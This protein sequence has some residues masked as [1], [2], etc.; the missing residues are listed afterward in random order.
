ML[1]LTALQAFYPTQVFLNGEEC[2]LSIALN[3]TAPVPTF[4]SNGTL[5]EDN[6][7][8]ITADGGALTGWPCRQHACE[9]HNQLFHCPLLSDVFPNRRQVLA[10]AHNAGGEVLAEQERHLIWF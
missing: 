7:S 4:A 9:L 2:R 6:L 8:P 1:A 5:I 10:L 3:L